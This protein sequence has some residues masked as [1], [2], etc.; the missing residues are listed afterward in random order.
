MKKV[1]THY[2]KTHLSELIDQALAGEEIVIA[3]YDKPMVKLVVIPSAM[4][5]RVF[6]QD[7]GSW[8]IPE[9]FNKPMTEEEL[10][11]WSAES[12]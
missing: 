11:A 12:A 8:H 6:G 4:T 2:A 3:R 9:D 7:A 10:A 5:K 1:S